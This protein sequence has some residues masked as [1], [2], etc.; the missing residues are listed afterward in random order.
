MAKLI[1]DTFREGYGVDQI[2]KTMTVG[3]LIGFLSDFD[4]D[5]PVY[6]GFDNRYTYG[7]I[8]EGRFEMDYGEED[9]E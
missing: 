3:E 4:E 5:T 9:D 7:G 2:R 1:L 6:L 8:T